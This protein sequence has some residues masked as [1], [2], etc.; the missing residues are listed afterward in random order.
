MSALGTIQNDDEGPKPGQQII[1]VILPTYIM[2]PA[3]NEMWDSPS[4][5]FTFTPPQLKNK[6]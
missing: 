4:S 1:N 2:K 3:E 6:K 5:L